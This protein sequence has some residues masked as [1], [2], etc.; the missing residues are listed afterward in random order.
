MLSGLLQRAAATEDFASGRSQNA[1]D[2]FGRQRAQFSHGSNY[3]T[4]SNKTIGTASYDIGSKEQ[5]LV[6]ITHESHRAVS[7]GGFRD[8]SFCGTKSGGNQRGGFNHG[9]NSSSSRN[10]RNNNMKPPMYHRNTRN[11]DASYSG[12]GYRPRGDDHWRRYEP[13]TKTRPAYAA[14]KPIISPASPSY[15]PSFS[16]RHEGYPLTTYAP[17]NPSILPM[18]GDYHF[19]REAVDSR[20]P[21]L[22]YR[23]P[24]SPP[25]YS[26]VSPA[27]KSFESRSHPPPALSDAARAK[28][29]RKLAVTILAEK[30]ERTIAKET[31]NREEY[32]PASPADE[33]SPNK[34]KLEYDP[35]SPQYF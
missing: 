23:S 12:L 35:A 26:P 8:K 10:Q 22:Y 4:V 21:H 6:N 2:H 16:I 29:K 30:L 24:T 20:Q 1:Q 17:S 19:G 27:Y 14:K 34:R 32:D 15:H 13:Y 25:G 5:E 28:L 3:H 33:H 18:G 11:V 31:E 9:S 7:H